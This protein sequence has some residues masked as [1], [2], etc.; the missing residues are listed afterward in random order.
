[1]TNKIENIKKNLP[2]ETPFLN[3][4]KINELLANNEITQEEATELHNWN[5]GMD[6]F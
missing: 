4:I 5:M 1:M 2:A 3:M 6:I